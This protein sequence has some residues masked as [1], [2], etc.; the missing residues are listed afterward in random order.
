MV[1]KTGDFVEYDGEFFIVIRDDDDSWDGSL[2]IEN[3]KRTINVHPWDVI[4]VV[5][6]PRYD[7]YGEPYLTRWDV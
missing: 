1:A 4:S 3:P 7:Q 5:Y 2:L 6:Y